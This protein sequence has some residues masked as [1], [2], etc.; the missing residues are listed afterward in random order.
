[1]L[2]SVVSAAV[3]GVEARWV[4]VEVH[5]ADGLPA[6][7]VVGLPD[8]AVRESRDRVKSALQTSGFPF[9]N[10]RVTVN[11]APGD[12][13]KE[14]PAFDLP[15]ALGVLAA[16]GYVSGDSLE[17]WVFLGELALDG[18]LRPV[19]GVLP[20]AVRASQE[21]RRVL[22]PEGN[23]PEAA[24][25]SGGR[26]YVAR[27]LSEVVSF[28]RGEVEPPA[29]EVDSGRLL[30]DSSHDDVDM[31]DVK[32]QAY[33]KRAL[34]VAVA[35]GHNMLLVGPPGAGKTMLA[36]RLPTVF[37]R[38]TLEE[39]LETTRVH[40]VAGLLPPGK[41][42]VGVRP[43]RAPHHT[44]SD[45][46]LVGGGAEPRPG[47][48][49][50]AHNGVLFL[51]ELSEFKRG[52]LEALRQPLEDGVVTISRARGT[53]SF[54]ARFMLVAAMNP[55]PCGFRG[56]PTRSCTCKPYEVERYLS[57]ISG[58]LLDR[59]DVQVEV[60]PVELGKLEGGD[61]EPSA[62]LRKRVEEARR[63]QLERF[64]GAGLFCNAMIPPRMIRTFCKPTREAADLIRAAMDR[65]GMSARAY[66]RILKVGRT[67]ADL[68]GHEH[69][70][71]EDA[72]EAVQ[73]RVLDRKLWH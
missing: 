19:R 34:E 9:P 65:F 69:I 58:P 20:V 54:P 47:E 25:G 24:V 8:T 60:P 3:E 2:A 38:M 59:I 26:A 12:M 32:G 28:L 57:K 44:V 31:A 53:V 61:G 62:V 63:R 52:A 14:G 7:T 27:S 43:F 10:A 71:A 5:V 40:S 67:I 13:P 64:R 37:P 68:A 23:G 22:V 11:L 33:A 36:R 51:D 50:A 39:A 6:V 17:G 73:Y 41:A 30:E 16:T 46:G 18:G 1:M 72:A 4:L 35:G 15:I 70:E 29:V 48:V 56:H 66:D 45:A 55:C 49:S 42:L 21:G